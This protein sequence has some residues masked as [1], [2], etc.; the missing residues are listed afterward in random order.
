MS[1]KFSRK[2]LPKPQNQ[3]KCHFRAVSRP[4]DPESRAKNKSAH[5]G[6][7]ASSS[8]LQRCQT[9]LG[10]SLKFSRKTPP[11]PSPV[12]KSRKTLSLPAATARRYHNHP[13]PHLHHSIE[14]IKYYK[15]PS[16]HSTT[17]IPQA[18]TAFHPLKTRDFDLQIGLSPL[19]RYP[20]TTKPRPSFPP[21]VITPQNIPVS[22]KTTPKKRVF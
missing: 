17:A 15:P 7:C 2:T 6:R 9:T 8:S 4:P 5:I 16:S 21:C 12:P 14:Q 22:S 3:P 19:Y 11:N 18:A 10:S 20:I 1:L 13:M